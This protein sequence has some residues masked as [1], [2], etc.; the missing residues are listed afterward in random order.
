MAATTPEERSAAEGQLTQALRGLLAVAEAYPQLQA[1][2]NFMSLQGTLQQIEDAI[3]NAR[4]YY[5][6]VVRD[7]NTK[8]QSFPS[9]VV[10]GMFHFEPRQFFNLDSPADREVPAVKF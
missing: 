2:Q 9:N 6:A 7:Y 10:A 3:Q 5:N 8:V 1:N 4:R